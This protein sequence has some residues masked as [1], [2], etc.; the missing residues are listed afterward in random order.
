MG[1]RCIDPIRIAQ[2]GA[3]WTFLCCYNAVS[4]DTFKKDDDRYCV[5][6]DKVSDDAI[7]KAGL[8][9]AAENQEHF[10]SKPY[11]PN[12]SAAS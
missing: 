6:L 2:T 4:N 5:P 9:F 3:G 8:K 1:I 7:K 12:V 11:V 10:T